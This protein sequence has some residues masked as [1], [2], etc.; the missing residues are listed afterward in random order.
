MNVAA[1]LEGIAEPGGICVSGIVHD[2]VRDKLDLAFED[3]GEQA[4]KNIAR[5][6]RVYRVGLAIAEER[7]AIVG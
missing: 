2:Q 5:P 7:Q 3:L 1:R 6:L 4:L